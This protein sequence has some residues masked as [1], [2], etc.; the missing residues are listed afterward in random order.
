MKQL[1][2][3]GPD[4]ACSRVARLLAEAEPDLPVCKA[5]EHV[6]SG[7]VLRI[8]DRGR[9]VGSEF[10]PGVELLRPVHLDGLPDS[11]IVAAVRLR[12]SE[13]G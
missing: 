7:R 3:S 12:L 1:Y 5:P 4:E 6:A 10:G 9:C 11:Q 13:R 8:R 2:L